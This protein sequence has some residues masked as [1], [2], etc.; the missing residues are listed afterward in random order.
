MSQIGKV[1]NKKK[2]F[3]SILSYSL[4]NQKRM[5]YK[6]SRKKDSTQ[7]KIKHK[8]KNLNTSLKTF[9]DGEKTV[10]NKQMGNFPLLEHNIHLEFPHRTQCCMPSSSAVFLSRRQEANKNLPYGYNTLINLSLSEYN[11]LP[12]AKDKILNQLK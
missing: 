2:P 9:F 3:N 11:S 10:T 1:E 8:L 7:S 5:E 6:Q 12:A 4:K